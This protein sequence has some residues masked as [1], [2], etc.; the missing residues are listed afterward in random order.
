MHS[1]ILQLS[2][3]DLLKNPDK[4]NE[5]MPVMRNN[6]RH[7]VCGKDKNICSAKIDMSFYENS[8]ILAINQLTSNM[9][10]SK[11]STQNQGINQKINQLVCPNKY[12]WDCNPFSFAHKQNKLGSPTQDWIDD[13]S[14][15]RNYLPQ[16]A[17]NHPPS[18][19]SILLSAPLHWLQT[20]PK[21]IQYICLQSWSH[22][23]V[24]SKF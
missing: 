20:Q 7:Y 9:S 4:G 24:I 12:R 5:T 18:P 6:L 10:F 19:P 8:S 13:L 21:W 2:C 17:T 23:W 22:Q 15:W 14:N 1:T 16:D 3:F 11:C